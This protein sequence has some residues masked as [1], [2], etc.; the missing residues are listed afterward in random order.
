MLYDYTSVT[1][2]SVRQETDAALSTA[3]RL[4]DGAVGAPR[5][6]ESTLLPLELAGAELVRAYGRGA[7]MGHVHTDAEV[8]DAGTAAEE[9]INKWRVTLVF[10]SDLYDAVRAFADT[11]EARALTGERARLLEHWLRDFRRAGHELPADDRAELERLRT[12]LVE[13]EVAYQ[14]NINEYRDG[15]EVT[16]EQLAGLPD[17]YIDRL[18]PGATGGTYRVSLDYP[19]LNP[20]LDQARDRGLRRE[21]FMKHWNRAVETNRALLEEALDLRRRIAALHGEPTWAHHAMELKMAKRPERVRAFYAELL[22]SL[23]SKVREEL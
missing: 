18:S 2:D 9:R 17:D 15:I 23:A 21:L 22:P 20:F 8:R 16:R 10:R 5:A 4:V 3:D 14:R 13:V 19:E 7:F 11:D 1:A 6:F 12:R